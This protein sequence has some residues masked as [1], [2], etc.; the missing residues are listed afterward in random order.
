MLTL[1]IILSTLF[2]TLISYVVG[3]GL[4]ALLKANLNGMLAIP[5]GFFSLLGI[6]QFFIYIIIVLKL[7]TT[8]FF[9]GYLLITISIILMGII[10][11]KFDWRFPNRNELISIGLLIAYVL[12][13]VYQSSQRTLGSNGFDT[14]HYLSMVLEGSTQKF[15]SYVQYDNGLQTGGINVQYDFQSYYYFGSMLVYLYDKLNQWMSP[16]YFDISTS[17]FIWVSSLLYFSI[18]YLTTLAILKPIF[19]KNRV[20]ALALGIFILFFS[21]NFYYTNTFT[22][23]GN[24]YRT[25]I[26]VLIY[27]LTHEFMLSK[28]KLKPFVVL[29][30]I[31]SS[32]LISVS[33]S[34]FFIGAMALF[35]LVMI[36]LRYRSEIKLG[37]TIVLLSSP[38][39][40]FAI[41]YLGANDHSLVLRYSLWVF[42]LYLLLIIF[43]FIPNFIQDR[44]KW[45]FKHILYFALPIMILI[46]SFYLRFI[47][48]E[49]THTFFENHKR[50]D[51]VWYY[52]DTDLVPLLVNSIWFLSFIPFILISK[53]K[54]SSF[55][56]ILVITFINPI[57]YVFVY[58][59]LA[60]V[61][62]YRANE[63]IFN[64][65]TLTIMLTYTLDLIRTKTI[66]KALSLG[67]LA[68]TIVIS[69]L[70][71]NAFYNPI[72]DAGK[73]FSS[74]YKINKSEV[75]PLQVLK[76]KIALENY[77]N[78][79]VFSQIEPIRGFV[80][81]YTPI[82]NE[83]IRGLD[84]FKTVP[85]TSKLLNI[86]VNR[87]HFGQMIFDKEPDY[88]NTCK[89]LIEAKAD[90][91]IVNRNTAY[92]IS[93]GQFVPLYFRIRECAT[94][95]FTNDDYIL[96]QFYW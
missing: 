1:Y 38:T 64:V 49:A 46:F 50:Y 82:A 93:P 43:D 52:F 75:E 8:F 42:L 12:F 34:G 78:P 95:I 22:F 33:S 5:L 56:R 21:S 59:Y 7:P 77:Q 91:V 11:N 14:V 44:F 71:V 81:V 96:Y 28:I 90:F 74:L 94:D 69:I 60:S 18:N 72:F 45:F 19:K 36:L 55:L 41:F 25:L 6:N 85:E 88:A 48:V 66:K 89:Y 61:V 29:F 53:S 40:L 4:I 32:A 3:K 79:V 63:L 47:G 31:L 26:L 16:Y 15:F 2:I 80:D 65:F 20:L 37:R 58:Q 35:A 67:L 57:S 76:T 30:V 83:T 39:L 68:F 70:Q 51:M 73:E 92:E 9:I 17:I 62:Y 24:T 84:K 87:D 23:F 27:F 86:F 10:R 54:F 13:M